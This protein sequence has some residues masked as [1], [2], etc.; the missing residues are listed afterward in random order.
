[1]TN[2]HH[3]PEDQVPGHDFGQGPARAYPDPAGNDFGE[4]SGHAGNVPK[5]AGP[6]PTAADVPPAGSVPPPGS[7]HPDAYAPNDPARHQGPATGGPAPTGATPGGPATA[8]SGGARATGAS[9]QTGPDG[10]PVDGRLAEDNRSLGEIISDV[11]QG[12]SH[13]M[14]QELALAK[15]ELSQTAKRAGTGAG[16]FAGAAIGGLMVLVFLSQAL[17]WV[18]GRAIGSQAEPALGLSGLIVAV[19]W[20]I[21]A[22]ILAAV[23]KS[24]LN[25]AEG[26]PQTQDTLSKIPDAVKGNEEENR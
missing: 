14:R 22:G 16:M 10:L 11:S 7:V 17:W 3:R 13:L 2:P 5:P 20:A 19:V 26:V 24:Q 12:L 21:I 9:V 4:A 15:A 23:G 1:M 6:I 8:A 18:L 25:K